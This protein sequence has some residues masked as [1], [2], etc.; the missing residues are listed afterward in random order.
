MKPAILIV[1]DNEPLLR[2]LKAIF[3]KNFTVFTAEDGVDA[4]YLLSRGIKPRLVL[5]DLQMQNIDGYELV[6][7]LAT[8]S[9]YQDIPVILLSETDQQ[10]ERLSSSNVARV[11]R[12]PF[13]PLFLEAAVTEVFTTVRQLDAIRGPGIRRQP[14]RVTDRPD[15][16]AHE[17]VYSIHTITKS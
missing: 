14:E 10:D 2:L 15:R 4:I 16:M 7:H 12:K 9:L 6:A 5:C 3:E 13:D 17:T 1:D 11:I 8:S